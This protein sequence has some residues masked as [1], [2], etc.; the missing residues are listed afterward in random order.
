MKR[1]IPIDRNLSLCLEFK[2]HLPKKK[3]KEKEKEKQ[4]KKRKKAN[5]LNL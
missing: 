2:R 5:Q 3:D 1:N 4:R